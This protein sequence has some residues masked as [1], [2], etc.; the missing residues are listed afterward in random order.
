MMTCW[1]ND[2]DERPAFT[3]LKRQLKDMES[4]HKVRILVDMATFFYAGVSLNSFIHSFIHSDGPMICSH[5]FQCVLS[6][7]CF[8]P[9]FP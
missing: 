3:E 1:Q 9:L 6:L 8:F 7:D 4:L 5:L 2:P